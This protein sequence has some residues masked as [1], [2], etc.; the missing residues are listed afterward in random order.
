MCGCPW[1]R[2]AL[3][4]FGVPY[5]ISVMAEA[6]DFKFGTQLAFAKAHHKTT[7]RGKVGVVLG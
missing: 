4:N 1:A 5:D 3:Q 6:R 2:G 7:S